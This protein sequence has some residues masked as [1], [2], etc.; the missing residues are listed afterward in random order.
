MTTSGEDRM[1]C[2]ILIQN[3]W[4]LQYCSDAVASTYCPDNFK[5]F[6]IQRR[7]WITS[8]IANLYHV[9]GCSEDIIKSNNS[10]STPF[11][12]YIY[13]CFVSSTLSIATTAL[14]IIGTRSIRYS[15]ED[16][17][18]YSHLYLHYKSHVFIT[19][20]QQAA[21]DMPLDTPLGITFLALESQSSICL[22]FL[23]LTST[24]PQIV[25]R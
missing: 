22:F 15:I 7:R 9:L 13:A 1:L 18:V 24:W 3:G 23:Y 20:F 12:W 2:T 16:W 21:L 4:M 14:V 8:T 10:V 17:I 6:Y 11:V 25:R 19:N 5:D